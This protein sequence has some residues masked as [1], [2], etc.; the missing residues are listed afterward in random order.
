MS[1]AFFAPLTPI[2][3]SNSSRHGWPPPARC[4]PQPAS[5]PSAF[6]HLALPPYPPYAPFNLKNS[7]VKL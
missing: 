4:H 6:A 5:G 3:G 2:T 1:K 7:L